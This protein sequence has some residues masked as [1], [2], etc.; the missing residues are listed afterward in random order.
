MVIDQVWVKGDWI[1]TET[2]SRS[3]NS[4][5]KYRGQYPAILT[6]QAWSVKDL[7]YDFRRKVNVV[8]FFFK[9]TICFLL[10]RPFG[11][12]IHDIAASNDI[13]TV[14]QKNNT[15]RGPQSTYPMVQ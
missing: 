1:L 4:Q 12:I 11:S 7:L 15:L 2:K 6:E 9:I 14:L 3:I 13:I 10:S 8:T 5:K